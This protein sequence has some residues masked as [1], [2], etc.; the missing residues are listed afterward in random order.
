LPISRPPLRQAKMADASDLLAYYAENIVK[1]RRQCVRCLKHYYEVENIGRWECMQRAFFRTG[2]D[3]HTDLPE[4]TVD[5]PIYVRADHTD[6]DET[7]IYEPMDDLMVTVALLNVF[8][9]HV[10]RRKSVVPLSIVFRENMFQPVPATA[11]ALTGGLCGIR[12]YDYAAQTSLTRDR[13]VRFGSAP[14]IQGTNTALR[15]RP[16]VHPFMRNGSLFEMSKP[17]EAPA[18]V[19]D[20]LL[21]A[22]FEL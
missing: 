11:P 5:R 20:A 6:S 22:G 7:R 15:A 17:V 3:G 8:R 10:L 16:M 21:N 9:N 12:R 1:E 13:F 18:N 2:V 14:S 19:I 4:R